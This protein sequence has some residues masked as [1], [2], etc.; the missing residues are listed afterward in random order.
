M[1]SKSRAFAAALIVIVVA[2]AGAL[3][4]GY[5]SGLSAA[6]G[7]SA[8]LNG[9]VASVDLQSLLGSGSPNERLIDLAFRSVEETFYKPVNAQTLLDGERRGLIS[10]I[11]GHKIKVPLPYQ[12]ATG[13]ADQDKARINTELAF[14]QQHVGA[15]ISKA[16]L[17]Q[18]AIRG[19]MDA[20]KD[21]Y[22]VYLSPREIQ[23][24]NE[25]LQGGNFGGIGVYIVQD[26]K[27]GAILVDPIESLPAAKVGMKPGDIV[28]SVDG[29]PT[30]GL[31]L[32]SVEHLI[33]GPAGSTVHIATH[34][35][36]QVVRNGK[37]TYVNNPVP[38]NKERAYTIVRQTIHVPTV[39]TK[40]ESGYDYI[41]L[42]DF[43]KTSA[44]EVKKALL[45]G[46]AHNAKGYILDLRNNG[47][48]LL[49][50][51]VEISSFFVPQGPI[52][53]TINR[54][55]AKETQDA[56]KTS[57]GGLTPLV[58]LVNKYTASASEITAG[59]LQDYKLGE[60][61]GTKTFGKGV[62]QSIYPLP[63][64]GALKIT[65]ARYVTPL[66]RDIH[67]KGIPPDVLINQ[68]PDPGL[69]DTPNDH[70]LA[71]AKAYL[72]RTVTKTTL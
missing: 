33:R 58:V 12:T 3:F 48:G 11:E 2:L 21:P 67:H 17:T 8:D 31:K 49:D 10:G 71:A 54:H 66:G 39:K 36:T 28:D 56:L 72:K 38:A 6:Q 64:N 20:L 70:Q 29:Q 35:F 40:M 44:D 42:A 55:G 46:K 22:T 18:A 41:R 30:K 32:D 13:I 14:A 7:R 62:V 25:S 47:G 65:T 24:L 37:T 60:L 5:R 45:F 69:I 53:S 9:E 16:E 26:P 63:D 59:A 27:T 15:K 19:M 57:I 52:V 4:L 23:G 61:I 34:A 68:N 50:A 43:G 51:A 1:S